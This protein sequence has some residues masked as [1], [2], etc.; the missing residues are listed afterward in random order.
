M[1]GIAVSLVACNSCENHE[2]KND[3]GACDL[4]G[5]EF[6]DGCNT[7]ACVDTDN[8]GKCDNEGCDKETSNKPC[9]HKDADDDKKCDECALAFSDGCDNHSDADEDGKCDTAGCD[10]DLTPPCE[11]KDE[12]DDKRCDK[13]EKAYSDGCDNHSDADDNGECDVAGCDEAFFDGCDRN[14]CIDSDNDGK[15]DN[16][17]CDKETSNKPCTQHRDADDNFRCDKCRLAFADGCDKV[18]CLDTDGDGKCDNNRCDKETD[19]K[20]NLPCTHTDAD[21]NG[22]C[23]KCREAFSDGCDN[24]SDTDDNGVCDVEDCDKAYTDGCDV[25]PCLDTDNDG[26]CDNEGCDKETSNKPCTQHRDADDDGECDE[27]GGSFTDACDVHKDKNDDYVCDTVGCGAVVDDGYDDGKYHL[28][29]NY[30]PSEITSV[31]YE[32]FENKSEVFVRMYQPY[33]PYAYFDHINLSDCRILSIKIPI[34]IAKEPDENGDFTFT[35]HKIDNSF[36]GLSMSPKESYTLK[37]NKDNKYGIVPGDTKV[38]QLIDFDLRA[39]NIKLSENETIAFGSSSDTLIPAYLHADEANEYASSKVF[40]DYFEQGIG[41][42]KQIGAG[43]RVDSATLCFDLEIERTYESLEAYEKMIA[44]ELAYEAA[45]QQVVDQLKE[46]YKGKNVSVLGDSISTFEGLSNNGNIN[47]A[48]ATHGKGYYPNYDNSVGHYTETYWGKLIDDLDMELCVDNGWSGT[49]V[50]GS[51]KRDH[52]DSAPER[53]NQL[54]T[55]DGIEPD[56]ILFYMGVNDMDSHREGNKGKAPFG[57]LYNKLKDV[58]K[59]DKA[60]EARIVDEWWQGVLKTYNDNNGVVKFKTTYS[61][62]EQ[63]YALALY[64]MQQRYEGVEIICVNLL[65][66]RY[67]GMTAEI[68]EKFNRVITAIGTYFGATV[69]EQMGPMAELTYENSFL[70]SANIDDVAVHPNVTGHKLMERLIIKT[71]AEKYGIELPEKP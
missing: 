2:D 68:T 55:K 71:L 26:K 47:S 13:C 12:D 66:N 18:E 37:I 57:S 15:C 17:G 22:E 14:S 23:D 39:F 7:A 4:C 46:I 9:A 30:L 50:Y 6:F 19:N 11:H 16:E 5:Q 31:L 51:D 38:Y 44:D 28:I 27:C 8:D 62:F 40:D 32:E 45:Y 21:D 33:A 1:L 35:I 70:Y 3:N 25:Q 49:H 42:L 56:L 65:R 60:A 10:E 54:H 41:V 29:S 63:A 36:D 34:L 67:A 64:L 20:P 48:L 52:K 61:D 43:F 24:H 59:N 58:D 69:V 53:A